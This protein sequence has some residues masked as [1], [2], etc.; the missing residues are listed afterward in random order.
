[1]HEQNVFIW[2]NP[3]IGITAGSGSQKSTVK[4]IVGKSLIIKQKQLH[5]IKNL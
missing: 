1:M 3:G 5:I 4:A 2:D